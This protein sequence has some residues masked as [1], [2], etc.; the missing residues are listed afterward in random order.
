MTP[1]ATVAITA[2]PPPRGVGRRHARDGL[3][4]CQR[5]FL[6]LAVGDFDI[7]GS[8]VVLSIVGVDYSSVR[9]G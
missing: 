1:S 2:S 4:D 9:A 7:G 6:Q 8:Q 5:V 3:E